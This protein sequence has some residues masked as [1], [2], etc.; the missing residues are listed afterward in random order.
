M[1]TQ[2]YL[3][4]CEFCTK[5]GKWNGDLKAILTDGQPLPNSGIPIVRISLC[6]NIKNI[7]IYFFNIYTDNNRRNLIHYFT[8]LEVQ[9]KIALQM[10]KTCQN[11]G[12]KT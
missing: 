12:Q 1:S 7:N 8:G 2:N 5:I 11:P 10:K 4:K 9:M 3:L 6:F